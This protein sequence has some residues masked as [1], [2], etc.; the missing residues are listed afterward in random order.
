MAGQAARE[1]PAKPTGSYAHLVILAGMKRSCA[2][3]LF[4]M[5]AF[6][7]PAQT[8]NFIKGKIINGE[9]GAGIPNA[10]VFITNSSKGTVSNNAGEFELNNV[11]EG[12]YELVVSCISYETQVYT[13]KASQLPLR[14][15]IQMKPK[16]DELQAVVVEPYEKNG[17][18]NW[19]KFF[20][21]NFIGAS[22]NAKDCRIVNYQA[23]H[24]R[25]SKKK[26]L[27]RVTAEEPLMIE[28][29]A[30]GYKIQ[31]QLEEFSY[32]FDKKILLYF[33]YT[34]FSDLNK[35]G[36]KAWQLKNRQKA[37]YGSIAHFMKSCYSNRLQE[38]GF[39]V[40]R[41]S[42]TPNLEK[43]RV[44]KIYRQQMAAVSKDSS[45]YYE[46]ILRQPDMFETYG[47]DLLTAD[48]LVTAI[49]S[50]SKTLFFANYLYIT[51]K[52]EKEDPAYLDFSN[53]RRQP[54]YQRSV[55]FLINH[56]AVVIEANGNYHM[57]QDLINYGY[58]GWSE[59]IAS[60]LPVD[61]R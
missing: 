56:T 47:K 26:N 15:Q 23:L 49:D 45:G 10:S 40:K 54:F 33:G 34:L 3:L 25:N 51:Y 17:W 41:L 48:S 18:E 58:W 52:K 22:A 27:L 4:S 50:L 7:I 9:T 38:E 5:L 60:M 30:L 55:L 32:D 53:E 6:K 46:K 8:S 28:N 61:Y 31:Y 20:T 13:Y 44:K 43:K 35:K 2:F 37:Y 1:L 36:P 21:E 59:K 29:R 14:I 11:P 57:P 12:N 42:K 19:G 24:F 39:E 16:A